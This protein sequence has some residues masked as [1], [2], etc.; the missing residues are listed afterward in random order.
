LA[1]RIGNKAA[2]D[3]LVS[4]FDQASPRQRSA[5]LV[6]HEFLEQ[7]ASTP[8]QLLF[9]PFISLNYSKISICNC[10]IIN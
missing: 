2:T 9:E 10:L 8:G 3:G 6:A 7:T 4:A 1:I 5:A